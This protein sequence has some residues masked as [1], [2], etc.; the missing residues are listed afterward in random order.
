[1]LD[2]LGLAETTPGPLILVTEFVGF[3]A[4]YRQGGEPKLAFGLLGAGDHALGDVH[5]LLSVDLRR[6]TLYR[7]SRAAARDSPAP[8]AASPPPWSASF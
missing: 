1:M 2:G 3:L 4:G 5:A 7:A 8:S 6:R